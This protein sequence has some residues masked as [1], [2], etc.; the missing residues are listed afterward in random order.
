MKQSLLFYL[1]ISFCILNSKQGNCQSFDTT[2]SIFTGYKLRVTIFNHERG[3]DY[4]T[5]KNAVLVFYKNQNGHRRDMFID[6]TFC[7]R[8]T[9]RLEDFNNDGVKDL[10]VFYDWDV[11]SN[12]M[13]HLYLVNAKG[14]R[15]LGVKGFEN[16]KNP[17]FNKKHYVIE[18]HVVSGR[19]YWVYYRIN[20]ANNLISY[21][22]VTYD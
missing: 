4:D 18:S 3:N 17:F 6:S 15:L 11:R 16:V 10:L 2:L 13:Y 5:A 21:K 12:E 9:V 8:A 1:F 7:S 19:N 22:K 20:N 14:K